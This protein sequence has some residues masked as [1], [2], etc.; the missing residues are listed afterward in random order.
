MSSSKN[1]SYPRSFCEAPVLFTPY[2]TE[3]YQKATMYNIGEDGMYM[4]TTAPLERGAD[5]CIKLTEFSSCKKDSVNCDGYRGEV[6]WI[7]TNEKNTPPVHCA[8]ILFK[9]KGR[10]CNGGCIEAMGFPCEICRKNMADETTR[11][12]SMEY[13]LVC[14]TCYSKIV[15]CRDGK[16]TSGI[17]NIIEGNVV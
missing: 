12:D 13:E 8:G 3:N 9:V 2:E 7:H 6:K 17:E 10:I 16:F 5:V 14:P 15:E 1:R 11:R 4:E